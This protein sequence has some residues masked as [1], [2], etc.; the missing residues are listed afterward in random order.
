MQQWRA[1]GPEAVPILARA[2]GQGTSPLWKWYQRNWFKF[3]AALKKRLKFPQDQA[4]IRRNAPLVLSGLNCDISAAAPALGRALHDE[5]Q[6]V[7]VNAAVCLK[8]LLPKLGP[9][10]TGIVPELME[11]MQDT[12][13][14]VRENVTQCLG[15]CPEQSRIVAPVLVRAFDDPVQFNRYLAVQS[16]KRMNL[17]EACKGGVGPMLVRSL[18]NDDLIVCLNAAN[19]LSDMKCDPAKEVPVF[20]GMLSDYRPV[21]QHLAAVALGKYGPQAS[22]AIPVLRHA[23]ETGEPRVRAAAS[24]ALDEIDPQT[25]A[26]KSARHEEP[27]FTARP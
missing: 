23:L 1:L 24:N 19:M 16:L 20:T 22:S 10:K 7:R 2:L 5:D 25:A 3:P 26:G 11:A 12:N 17:A 18:Q 15:N 14:L 13:Q 8:D 4:G 6:D 21:R 9:N 27:A